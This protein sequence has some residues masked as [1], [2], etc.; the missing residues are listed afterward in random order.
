MAGTCLVAVCACWSLESGEALLS[1]K[2]NFSKLTFLC[3]EICTLWQVKINSLVVFEA[4]SSDDLQIT[5]Q[6]KEGAVTDLAG[7]RA[8]LS[9]GGTG[10]VARETASTSAG[11]EMFPAI[12]V[13]ADLSA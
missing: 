3:S 8:P 11:T 9:E 5:L 2:L 10:E 4:A 13:V 1:W 7:N 6:I 12:V